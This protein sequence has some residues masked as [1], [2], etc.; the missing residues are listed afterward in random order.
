MLK[1]SKKIFINLLFITIIFFIF[2]KA[3]AYTNKVSE[4][5]YNSIFRLHIVA[6]SDSLE[7][8]QLK[9]KISEEIIKYLKENNLNFSTKSETIKFIKNNKEIINKKV[10]SIINASGYNY[11]YEIK[12]S[13]QYFPTKNY[14]NIFL[15]S[16]E[17]DS[18]VIKIGK[19]Q[20]HNWWC[21]IFP[22]LSFDN[23]ELNNEEFSLLTQNNSEKIIKFKIIE[24]INSLSSK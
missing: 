22:S 1:I 11:K 20:G 5:L 16:G 14:N 7:D 10:K 2:S 21:I 6:N 19:A 13:K 24:L 4:D 18:L 9:L 8:Q 15:P 23:V 3:I 17:Y 12:I